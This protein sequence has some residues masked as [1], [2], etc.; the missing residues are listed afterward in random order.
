MLS[1][2]LEIQRSSKR[3]G[4]KHA[5][6]GHGCCLLSR[7]LVELGRHFH[8]AQAAGV[9]GNTFVERFGNLLLILAP[10]C[11]R[12]NHRANIARTIVANDKLHRRRTWLR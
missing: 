11:K 2:R 12:H 5:F 6:G 7:L 9:L 4:I 3:I 1:L 10:L 8:S